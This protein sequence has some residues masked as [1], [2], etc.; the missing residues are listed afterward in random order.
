MPT[1]DYVTQRGSA[2]T[3]QWQFAGA[4]RDNTDHGRT[5]A[6]VAQAGDDLTVTVYRDALLLHP[7]AQGARTGVGEV[8]LSAANV[9]GLTGAVDLTDACPGH[10]ELDVFYCCDADLVARHTGVT[11]HLTEGN[12]AGEPG[13]ANPCARAKRALDA[14][15]AVRLGAQF[16]A[17]SLVPLA[18]AATALALFFLYEWLST[19]ADDPAAALAAR[20]RVHA[21]Q[22]L[23]AITLQRGS[24][25]ITPFAARV[26]RA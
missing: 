5:W 25:L 2:P 15:L 8:E 23:G 10:T 9:S 19:Q 20:F 21:Q 3:A 26:Q 24:E 6:T 12:F 18:E 4:T 13:F 17:E 14:M 7:V 1:L 11:A 16:R 22:A